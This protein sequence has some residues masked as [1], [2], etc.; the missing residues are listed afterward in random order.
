MVE[1]TS[2]A[3]LQPNS[4]REA[5]STIV[6]DDKAASPTHK[7]RAEAWRLE[8]VSAQPQL[9]RRETPEDLGSTSVLKTVPTVNDPADA[10]YAIFSFDAADSSRSLKDEAHNLH[11]RCT[12]LPWWS[13][14]SQL[15]GLEIDE[16]KER[17][18]V[19]VDTQANANGDKRMARSRSGSADYTPGTAKSRATMGLLAEQMEMKKFIMVMHPLGKVRLWWN[20]FT[21]LLIAYDVWS[22]PM[23]AFDVGH[24]ERGSV[25]TGYLVLE[26]VGTM[27][28]TMDLLA[29]FRTGFIVGS[30]VEMRPRQI[31]IHY[32]KTW[33]LIDLLIVS[34]EW[35]SRF[36]GLVSSASLLRSSRVLKLIRFVK[37]MR[38]AKMSSVWHLLHEQLNSNVLHLCITMVSLTVFLMVTIH[39][40]SCMWYA[41]GISRDDGWTS[42]DAYE[43]KKDIIFWYTASA[44]WVISQLNGRTDLDDRRNMQERFFTC[45]VGVTMAVLIQA[46]FTSLVTKTMLD[47]SELVSVKTRR[48]K[49]VN[50]YLHKH[51]VPALL[52]SAV[53]R[54]A[55]DYHDVAKEQKDEDD[56][57]GILPG[58]MQSELIIAV[59]SPVLL[60]H[61][62]FS[63]IGEES[64]FYMRTLCVDTIEMV[65]ATKCD[66]I[67]DKLEP[68]RRML[69]MDKVVARYGVPADPDRLADGEARAT[70]RTSSN[71]SQL[72]HMLVNTARHMFRTNEPLSLKTLSIGE[73]TDTK[74][75]A[76]TWVSE[77]ALWVEWH[78]QGRLVSESHGSMYAINTDDVAATMQKCPEMFMLAVIYAR[79]F[80][81]ELQRQETFTD[82]IPFDV[83]FERSMQ[84][85]VA[86][87]ARGPNSA[88][89][90]GLW[91]TSQ[92]SGLWR[93][94]GV[95]S[96]AR[97]DRS[98]SS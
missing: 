6:S 95:K 3:T 71:V 48:I 81:E 27:F 58:H 61:P 90:S 34:I 52:I 79:T 41:L 72:N 37:L 66:I 78:H 98:T 96:H 14:D 53:K 20:V 24:S 51:P 83:Q 13:S 49:M 17:W 63:T 42:Y 94:S 68:C 2:I 86:S 4:K 36:A 73:G 33:L 43:G 10:S 11:H 15:E 39:C 1:T 75:L 50:E 25:R 44:R 93:T 21:L 67:F 7:K 5:S 29:S 82:V 38:L 40:A 85:T 88:Q 60:A 64:D 59:R 22:I 62:L 84:R 23:Q 76:G 56:V 80:V 16:F 19:F 45:L 30:A 74:V 31:A 26:W 57:L 92:H 87:A 91:R 70:L 47:L 12:Q 69:F 32:C 65:P 28:W 9:S 18:W 89:H 54:Y 35:V 46:V 97:Y 8:D 77:P 55:S